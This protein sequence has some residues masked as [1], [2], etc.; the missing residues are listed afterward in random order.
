MEEEEEEGGG[1]INR[2]KVDKG[3]QLEGERDAE[4]VLVKGENGD[5][6]WDGERPFP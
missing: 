6:P 4:M 1:Q 3:R 5:T 2:R